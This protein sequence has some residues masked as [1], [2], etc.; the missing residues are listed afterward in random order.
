MSKEAVGPYWS[1]LGIHAKI[2]QKEAQGAL[3]RALKEN[4]VRK[5]CSANAPNHSKKKPSKKHVQRNPKPA[6]FEA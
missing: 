4:A 5:P 6:R 3:Y 1:C 2:C